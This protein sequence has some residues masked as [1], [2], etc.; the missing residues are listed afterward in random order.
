MTSRQARQILELPMGD[1]DAD[2]ATVRDYLI[3]LLRR[4]WVMNEEFSGKYPFGNSDWQCELYG[5]LAEAG[6]IDRDEND[7]HVDEAQGDRL[8]LAAIDYLAEVELP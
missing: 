7:E 4:V 1:N 5:E 8:I 6:L 3:T 2:A